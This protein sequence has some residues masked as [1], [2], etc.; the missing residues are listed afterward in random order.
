MAN[1]TAKSSGDPFQVEF[2]DIVNRTTVKIP[3]DEVMRGVPVGL[4][5]MIHPPPCLHKSN[6]S[7]HV[8]AQFHAQKPTARR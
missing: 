5:H 8:A 4:V 3:F 2:Y 6:F 7:A 1:S